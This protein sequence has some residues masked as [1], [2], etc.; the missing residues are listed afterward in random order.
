MRKEINSTIK[1]NTSE[2][3]AK[4]MNKKL[5]DRE[6]SKKES[7]TKAKEREEEM[8]AQEEAE[9]EDSDGETMKAPRDFAAAER[10]RLNDVAQA[11]PSLPRMNRQ[12]RRYGV[13]DSNA[14]NRVGAPLMRQME[15]ERERQRV[16][17][18]YRAQKGKRLENWVSSREADGA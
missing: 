9:E 3:A 1:S 17:S 15:L 11:P 10:V 12:A 5:E 6:A 13:E 2:K 16:I 4:Q 14:G 18:L 7:A 8:K